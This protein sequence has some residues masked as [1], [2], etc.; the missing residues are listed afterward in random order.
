MLAKIDEAEAALGLRQ[1]TAR[2][3]SDA[4]VAAASAMSQ[5]DRDAM[6]RGMVEGLAARL[7]NQPDDLEGW[8]MLIRSYA[9]L[10][11]APAAR[12]AVQDAGVAFRDRPEKLQQVTRLADSLGVT[13]Q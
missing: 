3:P 12:K 7:E 2:G 9:V 5:E 13:T 11:D 10:Q 6:V 4:D 8:L 1:T